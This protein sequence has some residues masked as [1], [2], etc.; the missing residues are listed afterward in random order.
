M[1]QIR[2]PAGSAGHVSL[3]T[4]ATVAPGDLTFVPTHVGFVGH[5]AGHGQ[6]S[7]ARRS[8]DVIGPAP[9]GRPGVAP[10]ASQLHAA[11][12]R[13]RRRIGG[14]MVARQTARASRG[15]GR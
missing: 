11:K 10:D 7:G 6:M 8:N 14:V 15:G 4:V 5:E 13:S 1:R 9:C 3:P 12:R 2:V